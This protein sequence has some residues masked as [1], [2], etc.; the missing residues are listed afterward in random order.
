MAAP[1]ARQSLRKLIRLSMEVD[2]LD[3]VGHDD[4]AGAW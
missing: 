3:D 4:S 1:E 2:G